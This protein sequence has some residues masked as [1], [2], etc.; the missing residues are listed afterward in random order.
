MKTLDILSV[1]F[2]ETSGLI[3]VAK[4]IVNDD[5]SV[6]FAGQSFHP[7]TIEWWA[8]AY[9]IDDPEE[10]VELVIIEPHIDNIDPMGMPVVAAR[11]MHRARVEAFKSAHYQVRTTRQVAQEAL[12]ASELPERFK[13]AGSLDPYQEAI[14]L[15]RFNTDAIKLKRAAVKALRD[16]LPDPET[17]VEAATELRNKVS[18]TGRE[19]TGE[20]VEPRRSSRE[21][22]PI[23]LEGGKKKI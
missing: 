7:E 6:E 14:R 4:R 15:A 5:D 13:T 18:F 11:N 21:L 2:N 19:N 8:A 20:S 22:P 23:T 17:A 12:Q 10:L 16:K 1:S 3:E 9:G